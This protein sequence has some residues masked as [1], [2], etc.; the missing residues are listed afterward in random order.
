MKSN[1]SKD[2]SKIS[3]KSK[4][5]MWQRIERKLTKLRVHI[6]VGDH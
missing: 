4:D 5:E 6:L 3:C 2:G 1:K